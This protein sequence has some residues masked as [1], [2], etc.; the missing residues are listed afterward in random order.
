[1]PDATTLIIFAGWSHEKDASI[2]RPCVLGSK[3]YDLKARKERKFPFEFSHL[4]MEH[5]SFEITPPSSYAIE[6]VPDPVHLDLPFARY[7]SSVTQ[8]GGVLKY[9]RSLEITRMSIPKEEVSDLRDFYRAVDR[10][11]RDVAIFRRAR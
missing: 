7:R 2:G 8:Q 11:E 1:M 10:G 3:F 4:R 5:D 6:R 9:K